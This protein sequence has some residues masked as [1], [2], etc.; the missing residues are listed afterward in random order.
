AG[1]HPSTPAFDEAG[2]ARLSGWCAKSDWNNAEVK[3][4]VEDGKPSLCIEAA[5]GYCFGS[6]RL[7]VWL[8]AGRYRLE[9]QS[10]TRGVAGLPSQTG[11]GAGV[12]VLG[13]RRG[14]GLQDSSDWTAVRYTFTVQEDWQQVE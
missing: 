8:P 4:V 6:W 14:S 3:A 13:G 2:V 12:R 7:P 5:G 9:G 11:S 1:V 10:K